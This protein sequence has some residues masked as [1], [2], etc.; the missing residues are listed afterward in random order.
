MVWDAS[1]SQYKDAFVTAG[2]VVAV[3]L[4]NDSLVIN[5]NEI[6][7]EGNQS[8]TQINGTPIGKVYAGQI[9]GELDV[10]LVILDEGIPEISATTAHGDVLSNGSF[11]VADNTLEGI[12]ACMEGSESGK[13]EGKVKN[14]YYSYVDERGTEF[15][16]VIRCGY[17]GVNG[18]S[19]GVVYAEADNG[20]NAI[21]GIHRAR[22]SVWGG[23]DA[24]VIKGVN[25]L[26]AYPGIIY[27][28][29]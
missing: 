11:F 23:Y 3:E 17:I 29:S 24:I 16:D 22:L 28:Y 12:R 18:D 26:N 21:I 7:Y 13:L 19:G 27:A 9:G 1:S 6:V 8:P 14:V 4:P 25:I 10:A 2:H 5:A 15:E 20:D